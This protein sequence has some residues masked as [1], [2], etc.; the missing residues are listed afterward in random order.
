MRDRS[1]LI[2]YQVHIIT[3]YAGVGLQIPGLRS[4]FFLMLPSFCMCFSQDLDEG[5]LA[6][7]HSPKFGKILFERSDHNVSTKLGGW[8]P[9]TTWPDSIVQV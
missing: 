1:K 9:A 8:S 5:L 6:G 4:V 2:V 3:N 7:D